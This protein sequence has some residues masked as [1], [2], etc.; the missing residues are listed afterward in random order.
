MRVIFANRYFYPDQSATSRVVSK[1][2]VA[3]AARGL[4]VCVV[5]SQALHD[6]P[7]VRFPG[8]EVY[9]GVRIRRLRTSHFGRGRMVGRTLDYLHFHVAAFFWWLGNVSKG[10][11]CILCTDP[12][13]LSVT[14]SLAIWMKGGTV[15]NWIMDLFPETAL[16]LGLLRKAGIA[17]RMLVRLRNLSLNA[18]TLTICPTSA[19]ARHMLLQTG[20]TVP[21][22]VMPNFSDPKEINLVSPEEN[23]LR[24][25]W[26]LSS[27]FV[28]G[29]SGNFGRAH[30]FKTLLEA[31]LLLRDRRDICFL[32]IGSGQQHA[33]V[34]KM[35]EDS[36]LSNVIFKPLQPSELLAES[37]GASDLHVVS[38]LPQ[39]EYC[40]VPSKF[41]GILAAGR[42]TAFIGDRNGEVG[43][44][45]RAAG[46]GA[47][48]S[49]GDAKTLA[50]FIT[51][52]Q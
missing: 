18:A 8:E 26:G 45:A 47:A 50:H 2:A 42:P 29:Y 21:T 31:A 19:M 7:D 22:D 36:G 17:G 13:L 25:A 27:K 23:R 16:E 52:L 38:L 14:S 3:L 35:V 20:G 1:L 49:I 41:Y 9:E 5:T 37:L 4:D 39:L 28:V 6:R 10:D 40:I 30:E 46:C 11:I 51:R 32:L 24:A 34:R 12:P 15:V 33:F 43:R 44:A 48:I